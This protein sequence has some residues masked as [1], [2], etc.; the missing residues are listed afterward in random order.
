MRNYI[1]ID[2]GTTNSAIASFDGERSWVWKSPEQNDVTPSAIFIDRRGNKFVGKRAYD[3]APS[4][5]D[6]SATLFKRFVGTS[7]PIRIGDRDW[8][9]EECSAEVLKALS[10]YLTE[11]IRLD[12]GTGTVITVPAAF[13]VMQ[14]EAT[15]RAANMSNIGAVALMQE[16]VAA[17]MAGIES[18]CSE[19]TFLIY[20]LGGGTLDITLAEL[21]SGHVTLHATGGKA[22]C[23]GRDF[24]RDLVESVVRPWLLSEFDLPHDLSSNPKYIKLMRRSTWAAEIAKIELSSRDQA[25]IAL[26]EDEVRTRDES[27]EE[28]YLQLQISRAEFDPLIETLILESIEEARRTLEKAGLTPEYVDQVIFVGGPT[29]YKPLREMVCSELGIA[30]NTDINPMTAVAQGASLFAES[31]DWSNQRLEKK[32]SRGQVTLDNI[33]FNFH[34]RTPDSKTRVEVV[35]NSDVPGDSEFQI[36]SRD[37]GWTSGW[38]PLK[39]GQHVELSLPQ[40]GENLFRVQARSGRGEFMGLPDS[41]I[42]ITKTPATVDAIPAS[43]DLALEVLDK[44]GGHSVREVLVRGGD[45]LPKKGRTK[46]VA[47]E[48]LKAGEQ[49]SLVFKVWEGEIDDP[50]SDNQYVG[51]LKISGGDFDDGVIPSG[52]ELECEYEIQDGGNPIFHISVSAIGATFGSE[53]NFYSADDGMVNFLTETKLVA[54]EGQEALNRIEEMSETVDDPTLEDARQKVLPSLSLSPQSNDAEEA[55]GA[56]ENLQDA[57]R[58]ISDVRKKNRKILRQAE[59]KK[60]TDFFDEFLEQS[61]SPAERAAHKNLIR[62]ARN[63]IEH[64][65]SQFEYYLVQLR[66]QQ[67]DML[68]RQD[69]FVVKNFEWLV[70]SSEHYS[71]PIRFNQL[72]EIGREALLRDDIPALRSV[73]GELLDIRVDGGRGKSD[74]VNVIRG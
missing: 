73:Q 4:N 30:G 64:S 45:P 63:S 23:G 32:Q 27:N 49:E 22:M 36:V 41:L 38:M 55:K 31:V 72:V 24:D 18:G 52:A 15:L 9:P 61:C 26:T 28:I 70:E 35:A 56:K 39:N 50:I 54:N 8:S 25:V 12:P 66:N 2:L 48:S 10:G 68:W 33:V 40:F 60:T 34:A 74:R 69:W 5:P 11:E 67:F 16:P 62:T 20:D 6:Q 37:T 21:N 19:G 17:A 51:T 3:S 44:V 43:H 53:K 59:L 14:K 42:S 47:A 1:G 7:T 65:D 29:H 58:M 13:N 57:R 46:L 71:D